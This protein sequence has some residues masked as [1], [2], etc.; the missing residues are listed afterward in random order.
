MDDWDNDDLVMTL[1]EVVYASL[2]VTF[3]I[4]TIFVVLTL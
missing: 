1:K 4:T 3:I 2:G